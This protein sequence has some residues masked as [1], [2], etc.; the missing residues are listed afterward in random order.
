MSRDTYKY[1]FK[2]GNK[3]VYTG[4]TIDLEKREQEHK[5]NFGSSGYI[6]KVGKAKLAMLL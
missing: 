4:I 2:I 6:H 5:M 1:H 3:I